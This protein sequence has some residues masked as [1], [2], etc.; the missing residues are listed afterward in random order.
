M[1]AVAARPAP[2]ALPSL[3]VLHLLPGAVATAVFVLLA[4]P[5]ADAGYPPLAAFLLA[6]ALVIVPFEL[7]AV[8]VAGRR[9]DPAGG[10][11]AAIPYRRPLRRRD[12]LILAP[13]LLVAAIVGFGLLALLE[14]PIRDSL[15]SWLPEWFVSPVPLESIDDYS[16]SAWIVTLIGFVVLNAV[17]GPTVE[18]L[19]FR[20]WLLPRMSQFGRWA[21]LVNVALFSLYHFW[22]PWQFLSRIAGVLPFAYGVWWKENVLLGVVVHAALNSISVITVVAIV[23]A[24]LG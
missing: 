9:A 17:I 13:I 1:T 14:G 15:F 4:G 16:R 22:S 20:G 24:G 5:V 21:P 18:E 23:S 12:W 19:Y 2:M 11:L 10:I 7:G 8:V 6:I 3:L